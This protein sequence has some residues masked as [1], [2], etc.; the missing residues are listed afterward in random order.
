MDYGGYLAC[1]YIWFEWRCL[2]AT[3]HLL[4]VM[5]RLGGP[6]RCAAITSF[7]VSCVRKPETAKRIVNGVGWAYRFPL[8][9]Y[10]QWCR[11]KGSH[12]EAK[13]VALG[14]VD[15]SHRQYATSRDMWFT[16]ARAR[17]MEYG[18]VGNLSGPRRTEK[19]GRIGIEQ[20]PNWLWRLV[21]SYRV[22]PR[23]DVMQSS[24][25]SPGTSQ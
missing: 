25:Q 20:A 17:L 11:R 15:R 13:C 7:R 16:F 8:E 21:L 9:C 5:L 2:M 24:K 14:H 19:E 12:E 6:T 3:Y 23:S 1:R 4:S 10:V 22:S 18:Q